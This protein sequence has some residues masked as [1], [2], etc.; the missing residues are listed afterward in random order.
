MEEIDW[1]KVYQREYILHPIIQKYNNMNFF[2]HPKI[3]IDKNEIKKEKS[4]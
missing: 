1:D 3:F 2:T 4:C